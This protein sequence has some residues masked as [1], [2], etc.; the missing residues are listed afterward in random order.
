MDLVVKGLNNRLSE[1]GFQEGDLVRVFNGVEI[2]ELSQENMG[3]LNMLFGASFSWTPDQDVTFEVD[4]DG[5]RK[6]LSGTVGVAVAAAKGIVAMD[7]ATPAQ[8][9][10]RN[11]WL[12]GE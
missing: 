9:V 4:R 11:A 3:A 12:Y 7:D 8:I 2:P 10:L 6:T 1:I 5:E